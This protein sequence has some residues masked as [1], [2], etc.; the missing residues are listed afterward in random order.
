M[1]S[2]DDVWQEFRQVLK[3][4]L[5]ECYPYWQTRNRKDRPYELP[6]AETLLAWVE[7]SQR[8]QAKTFRKFVEE[9]VF[10]EDIKRQLTLLYPQLQR[11]KTLTENTPETQFIPE[12]HK[13]KFKPRGSLSV[14][15]VIMCILLMSIFSL[16]VMSHISRQNE[17]K[18]WCTATAS[19]TELSGDVALLYFDAAVPLRSFDEIPFYIYFDTNKYV[20]E[21]MLSSRKMDVVNHRWEFTV[22]PEWIETYSEWHNPLLWHV[23]Y[24]C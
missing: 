20:S 8:P 13:R 23:E 19:N 16:T 24:K 1:N 10:P 15:V 21:Q 9:S 7:G 2:E 12:I 3:N 17:A 5:N 18:T 22:S 4:I 6:D 11:R 14:V